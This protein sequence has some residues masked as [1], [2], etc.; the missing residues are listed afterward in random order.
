MKGLRGKINGTEKI[1]KSNQGKKVNFSTACS[2]RSGS[3]NFQRVEKASPLNKKDIIQLFASR[4]KQFSSICSFA[5]Q[6]RRGMRRCCHF[7][8]Q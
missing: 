3:I 1:Q 2:S 5:N 4:G 8:G 6:L 7:C